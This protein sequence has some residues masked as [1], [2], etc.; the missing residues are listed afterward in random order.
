MERIRE[1][2]GTDV[3]LASTTNRREALRKRLQRVADVARVEDGSE[4]ETSWASE[5]GGTQAG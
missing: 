1:H 3:R 4:E 5:D 2:A